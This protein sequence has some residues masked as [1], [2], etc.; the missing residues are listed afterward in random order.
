[1]FYICKNLKIIT[2][3]NI[4]IKRNHIC[5]LHYIIIITYKKRIIVVIRYCYYCHI[6]ILLFHPDI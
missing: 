4:Y 3:S 1:M 2:I 5:L 6:R